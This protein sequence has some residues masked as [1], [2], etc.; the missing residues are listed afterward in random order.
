MK[1]NSN[2]FCDFDNFERMFPIAWMHT[3][4][5]E[6]D[7]EFDSLDHSDYELETK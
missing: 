5:I 2:I 6:G 7:I 4:A 3:D 1:D